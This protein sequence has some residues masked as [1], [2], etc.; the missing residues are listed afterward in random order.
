[1]IFF[2]NTYALIHTKNTVEV[3]HKDIKCTE[4]NNI[5]QNGGTCKEEPDE[6]D[7]CDCPSGYVG[8]VCEFFEPSVPKCTLKCHN[9][10]SCRY[11]SKTEN[12]TLV[13]D[14]PS[15]PES[16]SV[17]VVHQDYQYCECPEGFMGSLCD[18]EEIICGNI[19]CLHGTKCIS[20]KDEDTDETTHHC[21]CTEINK[22][23]LAKG[24]EV[25]FSGYVLGYLVDE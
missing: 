12:H 22:K 18:K 15:G 24:E 2:K 14:E 11:G 6:L 7:P 13:V 19:K 9:G 3:V 5:C 10:G 21:D 23:K 4:N 25:Q 20:I 17:E 1:L 8:R 16:Q